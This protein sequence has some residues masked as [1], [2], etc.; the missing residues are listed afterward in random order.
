MRQGRATWADL[1]DELGLTA[2][3]IAQRV[4]RIEDRG[5][6]QQFAAWVA[7]EAVAPVAAFV[8]LRCERSDGRDQLRRR[9]NELE[10]VQ[11]L[12]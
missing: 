1:A 10:Q 7:P 2:P 5:V 6:I 12:V 3:A 9:L 8:S 4:R 11:E